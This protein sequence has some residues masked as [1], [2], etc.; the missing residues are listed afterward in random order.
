MNKHNTIPVEV[1]QIY[2]LRI[3]GI[4]KEG[5]GI[6]KVK[7]FTVIVPHTQ[8]DE[9]VKVRIVRIPAP[10]FAVGEVIE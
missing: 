9:R 8:I 1:N 3:I 7:K 4:G 10:S 6:G 2:R 5:D